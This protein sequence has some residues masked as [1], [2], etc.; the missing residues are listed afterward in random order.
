M[1]ILEEWS[2]NLHRNEELKMAWRWMYEKLEIP[3]EMV[4]EFC[5]CLTEEDWKLLKRRYEFVRR[6]MPLEE[7]IEKDIETLEQKRIQTAVTKLRES[8]SENE[9]LTGDNVRD[10]FQGLDENE[11][12]SLYVELIIRENNGSSEDK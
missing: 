7:Y 1:S 2:K 12:V 11:L 4:R 6:G 8:I 3:E 5:D 10:V 9:P